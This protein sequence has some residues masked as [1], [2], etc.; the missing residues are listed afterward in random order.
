MMTYL[1]FTWIILW[2][3]RPEILV[4]KCCFSP[5]VLIDRTNMPAST[6]ET[7]TAFIK[8]DPLALNILIKFL[9]ITDC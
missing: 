8:K 6:A 9:Y 2:K 4:Y 1:G 3:Y 7:I 5:A